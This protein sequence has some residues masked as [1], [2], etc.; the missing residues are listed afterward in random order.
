MIW[1]YLCCVC[2][3]E[4]KKERST[5]DFCEHFDRIHVEKEN[6]RVC[7]FLEGGGATIV[8]IELYLSALTTSRR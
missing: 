8:L 1:E 2:V 5:V 7:C 6:F 4:R 3:C